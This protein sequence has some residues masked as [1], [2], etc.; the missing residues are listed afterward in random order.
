MTVIAEA[1]GSFVIFLGQISAD[2]V[3]IGVD[4]AVPPV[5]FRLVLLVWVPLAVPL[6]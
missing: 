3:G 4:V 6:L 1:A 2:G 5:G